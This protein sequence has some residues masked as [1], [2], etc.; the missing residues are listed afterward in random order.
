MRYFAKITQDHWTLKNKV[1]TEARMVAKQMDRKLLMNPH[2]RSV[3]LLN[4]QKMIDGVNRSNPR[5]KPVELNIHGEHLGEI[6]AD[7]DCFA[8]IPGNFHITIFYVH[9]N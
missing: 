7:R 8:Y 3:Y 6:M 9:D 5:C 1:N 4:L 2:E